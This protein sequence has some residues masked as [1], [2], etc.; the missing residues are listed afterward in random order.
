MK[1]VSVGWIYLFFILWRDVI[2]LIKILAMHRGCRAAQGM[3]SSEEENDEEEK[4]STALRVRC[5]NEIRQVIFMMYQDI[6]WTMEKERIEKEKK[7]RKG[8]VDTNQPDE[9]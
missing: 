5:Y 2:N 3:D 8:V 6:V 9:K 1:L 4:S 7:E